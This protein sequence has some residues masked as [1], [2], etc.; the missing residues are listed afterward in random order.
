MPKIDPELLN[1]QVETNFSKFFIYVHTL[2][3]EEIKSWNI[4]FEIN[5]SLKEMNTQK[6]LAMKN[7]LMKLKT[8]RMQSPMKVR[9]HELHTY[10]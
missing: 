6:N 7:I 3:L 9:F 2:E 5:Q 1:V 10:F 4:S 8:R